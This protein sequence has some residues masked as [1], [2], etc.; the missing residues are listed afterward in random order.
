MEYWDRVRITSWDWEW[1]T[2]RIIIVVEPGLYVVINELWTI[3]EP[4]DNL[5]LIE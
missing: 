5:E 4:E 3:S 1:T 2:W